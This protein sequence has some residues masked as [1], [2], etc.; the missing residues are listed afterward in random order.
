M[1]SVR[2]SGRKSR[3]IVFKLLLKNI[4]NFILSRLYHFYYIFVKAHELSETFEHSI[5]ANETDSL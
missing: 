5:F 4:I 2:N 1:V 3:I